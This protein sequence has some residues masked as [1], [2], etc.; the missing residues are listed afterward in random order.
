MCVHIRAGSGSGESSLLQTVQG[1]EK[2]YKIIEHLLL[3]SWEGEGGGGG[4]E[5]TA[6]L[7][8]VYFSNTPTGF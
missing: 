1:L 4:D 8:A 7:V 6:V 2:R 5:A 3:I